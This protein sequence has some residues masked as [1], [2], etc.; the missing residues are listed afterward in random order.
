MIQ[1]SERARKP[2]LWRLVAVLALAIGVRTYAVANTTVPSR[3]CIVFVRY[4]LYF[5]QPGG[6]FLEP[7][8][9]LSGPIEV[10]KTSEHPPGYPAAILLVSKVVRPVMGGTNVP[11][12]ALSAQLVSA[13]AAIALIVPGYFLIRRLFDRNIA[14]AAMAIFTVLPVFVEV[15]SDGI[16]DGL[17]LWT[18]VSAL[19]FAA[20]GLDAA[21][22]R[23][24]LFHGLGA[25]LC[26]GLGYLVR[27]DGA[28]LALAIGLT[29]TG[30][31]L[32]RQ[33][34]ERGIPLR[35][36]IGLVIGWLLFA[37]PYMALIGGITNK[38]TGR[39]L[40]GDGEATYYDRSNSRMPTVPF[41]AWWTTADAEQPK[42]LW[43][44]KAVGSEYLKAAH[45]AVPAFALIGLYVSRRRLTDARIALLLVFGGIHVTVLWFLATTVGYVSQR[46]T[47]PEAFVSCVFAAASFPA[48]GAIRWP[49]PAADT[50]DWRFGSFWLAILLAAALP[51][52]FRS[53]HSERAG[54]RAAG[55]WLAAN[56]DPSIEVL[57]PFGWTE[58][59]AGRTLTRWPNL[60]PT[61]TKGPLIYVLFEP[62]GKS[63]HSR[64]P[65]YDWAVSAAN[66]PD[67]RIVYQYPPDVPLDQIKVA[68][69]LCKTGK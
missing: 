25:G 19:W 27:P 53:L 45:Y 55:E 51:R 67:A 31:M 3:D 63:P 35:L 1:T 46:H 42:G 14:A 69:Y 8:R 44:A 7:D 66:R 39:K 40:S 30:T 52:D 17:F 36:G 65:R 6:T 56:G 33:R 34:G 9:Q 20:R 23:A 11:A 22:N 15:T 57:D 21:T 60:D 50:S 10:I 58:W 37:G 41:A 13:F 59:Y 68:V 61:Q 28:I 64:L 26:C 2:D 32:R 54:H 5:E 29:F 4:A 47:L 38:P 12:M 49:R 24:A 18:A 43:A 48:L 16:S 62:N